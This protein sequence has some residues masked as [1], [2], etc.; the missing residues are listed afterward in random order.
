[1]AHKKARKAQ[2]NYLCMIVPPDAIGCGIC[3]RS[4]PLR[5]MERRE[6]REL[7]RMKKRLSLIRANSRNSRQESFSESVSIRVHPWLKQSFPGRARVGWLR[8]SVKS[9]LWFGGLRFR[10][11]IQQMHEVLEH[12]DDCGFMYV[13]PAFEF[14]FERGQRAGPVSGIGKHRAHL[15]KSAHNEHAQV[16]R[17]CPGLLALTRMLGR[18]DACPILQESAFTRGLPPG[19]QRQRRSCAQPVCC[20]KRWPL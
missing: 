6:L 11:R 17:F 15:Q 3:A 19:M 5:R 16:N 20:S 8:P 10:R 12:F 13:K 14:G 9:D 18:R 1:M 7:S 4:F 2:R